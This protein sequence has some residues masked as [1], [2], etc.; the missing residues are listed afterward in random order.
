MGNMDTW[1]RFKKP[2]AEALKEIR[3]GRLSGKTDINPQWRYQA[4]TELFG[5]C[6][7]GWKFEVVR[8]WSEEGDCAE[9]FAFATVNL[10]YHTGD[11]WSAPIPGYG[12]SMIVEKE[13]AGLH[14]NDEGYKMAITDALGTA[15]KMLGIAADV[16]MGMCDSKY[17][18][19]PT[20]PTNTN[21]STNE[22]VF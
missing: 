12:G 6:G 2:P 5:P 3:G 21:S 4:M 14:N 15:M 9:K 22:E 17:Q 10:Y 20:Q 11:G 16:Y 1:N 19:K 8:V 18:P 7:S 13:K